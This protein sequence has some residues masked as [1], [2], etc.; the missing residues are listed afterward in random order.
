MVAFLMKKRKIKIAK[1][2]NDTDGT[3]HGKNLLRAMPA[4]I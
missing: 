1:Q 2:V 3:L 4:V